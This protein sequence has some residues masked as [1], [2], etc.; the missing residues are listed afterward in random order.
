MIPSS[1]TSDLFGQEKGVAFAAYQGSIFNEDNVIRLLIEPP[2]LRP[3]K[4]LKRTRLYQR[5]LEPKRTR[6]K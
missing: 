2:Q 4:R 6:D 5:L 3:S 1:G